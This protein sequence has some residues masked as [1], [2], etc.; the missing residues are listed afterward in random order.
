MK[1]IT[2][3]LR[4]RTRFTLNYKKMVFF[5]SAAARQHGPAPYHSLHGLVMVITKHWKESWGARPGLNDVGAL[6]KIEKKVNLIL[7]LG[8][9]Y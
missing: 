6:L 1:S 3:I 7:L 9:T 4:V 5:W 8:L 2:Y